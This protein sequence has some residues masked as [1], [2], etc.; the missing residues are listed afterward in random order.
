ML[1]TLQPYEVVSPEGRWRLEVKP[2]ERN[3][4]GPAMTSLINAGTG[5]I[6]WKQ[7]LPYTF[8]QCCVNEEGI[9]A[10]YGYTKGPMGESD[11][12]KEAGQFI[13]SFL[14]LRGLSMHEERTDHTPAWAGIY[15]PEL[16]ASR[17]YLDRSNDRMIL[18]MSNGLFRCYD[19]RNGILARAFCPE[20]KGDASGYQWPDAVRFFRD[21]DLILLESNSARGD[22][23]RATWTSCLQ[24]V[25]A[26]GRTVWAASHQKTLSCDYEGPN[27]EFRILETEG[28]FDRDPFGEDPKAGVFRVY[29]GNTAEK[30][31]FQILDS[32]GNDEQPSYRIVERAREKWTFPKQPEDDGEDIPPAHFPSLKATKLAG[33]QLKRKD[34]SLLSG[35]AAVALGPE[36]RIHVLDREN[37]QIQVF[38]QAGEFLHSCDPGKDDTLEKNSYSASIAVDESGE[39]FA[40]ISGSY[41]VEE[42]EKDLYAGH[43]LRFSSEGVLREKPLKPPSDELAGKIAIQPKSN[44]LIFY[45][46]GAEVA[47]IRRDENGSQAAKLTRR[48]DGH[49]LEYIQDVACAPNG[50]IAVRDTSAGDTFG[51]FTTPFSRLHS[52]RPAETITLYHTEGDPIRIIDFSRFAG[53]SQIDFDGKHIVATFPYDPPTPLVYLFDAE[54]EPIGAIRI[55]ELA[56]QEAVN[57]RAF[58][59]AGG[60]EILAIDLR[61]GITFRFK[62]P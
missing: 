24:V 55:A 37:G 6:V 4:S 47:V 42:G 14:D 56:D 25:D 9:V 16:W 18:V 40:K 44:H 50:M 60:D 43:F 58:I 48:F 26:G 33:F 34:G 59:V 12:T 28:A 62:I 11:E 54:G 49:W 5:E 10:G 31:T 2:G 27:L 23:V 21:S 61:S 39:V 41:A 46:S 35:I 15:L 20:A 8:W 30:V 53:L 29:L 52:H 3:G 1:P 36:N 57:L 32:S 7:M 38:D 19:M 22:G 17:L 45:G 51:G 13:V